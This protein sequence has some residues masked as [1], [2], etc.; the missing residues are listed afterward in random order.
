MINVFL[1]YRMLICHYEKQ[2]I[3]PTFPSPNHI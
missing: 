2:N 1:S 3:L